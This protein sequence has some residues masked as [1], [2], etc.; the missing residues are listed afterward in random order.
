M[1]ALII[2]I[3]LLVIAIGSVSPTASWWAEKGYAEK[4][5]AKCMTA[6]KIKGIAFR[7]SEAAEIYAEVIKLFPDDSHIEEAMYR[8]ANALGQDNVAKAATVA[9]EDYL[10]KFPQGQWAEVATKKLSM[11]KANN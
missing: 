5:A 7:N 2:C 1:R 3:V 9:Y 8:R 10:K 6:A 4:D 11:L